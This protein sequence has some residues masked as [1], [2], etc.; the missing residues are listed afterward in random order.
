LPSCQANAPILPTGGEERTIWGKCQS[1][2]RA[3]VA[4]QDRVRLACPH[5]PELDHSISARRSDQPTI[6]GKGDSVDRPGLTGE[7]TTLMAGGDIP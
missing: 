7:R 4:S 5:I 6:R 2:N 1:Q 3:S